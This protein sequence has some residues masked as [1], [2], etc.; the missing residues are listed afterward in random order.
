[1]DEC[2]FEPPLAMGEDPAAPEPSTD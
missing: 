2:G 1:M